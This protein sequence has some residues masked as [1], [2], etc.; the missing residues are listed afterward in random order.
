M[1]RR[2]RVNEEKMKSLRAIRFNEPD[3]VSGTLK[4]RRISRAG[5]VRR[6]EG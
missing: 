2:A 3:I 6:A 5:H 4:S 1:R